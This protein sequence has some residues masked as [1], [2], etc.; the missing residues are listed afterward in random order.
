MQ[1]T[2]GGGYD[3]V[4]ASFQRTN[5]VVR[6][7]TYYGGQGNEISWVPQEVSVGVGYVA[8]GFFEIQNTGAVF[9]TCLMNN[10]CPSFLQ[11]NFGG[12]YDVGFLVFTGN[13]QRVWSTFYGDV[14]F[15]G[16]GTVQM[17]GSTILY[18]AISTTSDLPATH[19]KN[20]GGG[21]YYD[22][23]RSSTDVVILRFNQVN[24]PLFYQNEES[25]NDERPSRWEPWK[26][27]IEQRDLVIRGVREPG[28]YFLLSDLS[29]K[30][31]GRWAVE[32]EEF[33]V[34][35]P[36]TPGVYVLR[37]EISGHVQKVVYSP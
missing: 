13:G 26:A 32:T 4:I 6:W 17:V 29:G 3:L 23:T 35:L 27:T 5:N 11:A 22:G 30:V 36:V 16:W 25:M 1:N 9:S 18:A 7:S 8:F 20:P 31:V 12:Q 34:S 15:E 14:G 37:E 24:C 2:R 21:A 10:N 33:R 28:S 19:L